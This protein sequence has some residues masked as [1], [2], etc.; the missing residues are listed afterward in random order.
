[1][2]IGNRT[3]AP[4]WPNAHG[5]GCPAADHYRD[6]I[7]FFLPPCTLLFGKES[8]DDT[9]V[10]P[11]GACRDPLR[12]QWGLNCAV[13][14]GKHQQAAAETWRATLD[15][16]TTFLAAFAGALDVGLAIL[17]WRYHHRWSG[18]TKPIKVKQGNRN[19][20][21]LLGLGG[22]GKTSFIRSLFGNTE[23][24]PT[25]ST[26]N[27]ELYQTTISIMNPRNAKDTRHYS[28]FVGDYRGQNLGQLIREF[29]TQQKGSFEPMAYGYINSL[30]LIVDLIPPPDNITDPPIK[31]RKEL[32][33]VRTGLHCAQWNETALDAVFGM[34]TS[35]SLKFVCLLVNK[36]DLIIGNE[37]QPARDAIQQQFSELQSRL[38]QRANA[39]GA[40]FQTIVGSASEGTGVLGIRN[41][42]LTTSV[43]G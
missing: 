15:T 19:S 21:M 31:P 13:D 34:L 33:K 6:T 40:N 14:L 3:E 5:H 27:Y 17:A 24:N 36:V 35:G 11:P 39:A 9:T 26:E 7:A 38:E 16:I 37:E 20:I 4:T 1:M 32:D 30:I 25:I 42:L 12:R 43:P 23:A 22:V 10:P 2:R 18:L 8:L 28:L 41:I 29:I